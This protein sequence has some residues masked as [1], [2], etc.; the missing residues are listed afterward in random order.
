MPDKKIVKYYLLCTLG[1]GSKRHIVNDIPTSKL[2]LIIN[3][4]D[5]G[6]LLRRQRDQLV[7]KDIV[8]GGEGDSD[9]PASVNEIWAQ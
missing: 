3:L 9:E 8:V 5:Q 7:A 2:P 1:E 6:L 4:R